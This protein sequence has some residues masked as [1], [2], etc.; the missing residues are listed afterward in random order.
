[1]MKPDDILLNMAQN[2]RSLALPKAERSTLVPSDT[3][4][5]SVTSVNQP[6]E[7]AID[8]MVEKASAKTLADLFQQAIA[9]GVLAPAHQYA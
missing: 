5:A 8:R 7:A 6:D 4:A 9:Q 2:M 1:M 3:P